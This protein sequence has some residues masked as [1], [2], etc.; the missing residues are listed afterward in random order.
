MS[1][2]TKKR[3]WGYVSECSFKGI[4]D[5]PGALATATR[6]RLVRCNSSANGTIIPYCL[7][8][9]RKQSS[10]T[11]RGGFQTKVEYIIIKT[12]KS[13]QSFQRVIFTIISQR[14]GGNYERPSKYKTPYKDQPVREWVPDSWWHKTNPSVAV[15]IHFV[16][17]A[18]GQPCQQLTV[19]SWR[20]LNLYFRKVWPE[21]S[22]I[23]IFIP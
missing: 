2:E 1:D 14:F 16:R 10:G 11:E 3:S 20:A 6:K 5:F 18:C 8:T 15:G 19:Q 4:P 12:T 7:L 13:T 23:Y 17:P 21:A 22:F 9:T